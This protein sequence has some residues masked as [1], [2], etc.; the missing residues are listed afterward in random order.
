MV[1]SIFTKVTFCVVE[2]LE[3][4]FYKKLK[5]LSANVISNGTQ[6]IVAIVNSILIDAITLNIH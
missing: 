3:G 1:N 4:S 5:K 6:A 2:N